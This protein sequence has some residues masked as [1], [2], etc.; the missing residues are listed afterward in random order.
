[1]RLAGQVYPLRGVVFE[2]ARLLEVV[3]HQQHSFWFEISHISFF[4][5]TGICAGVGAIGKHLG[6]IISNADGFEIE[7]LAGGNKLTP[8]SI[9]SA[10]KSP[11]RFLL[12]W[13]QRA[14][15]GRC[16]WRCCWRCF[17]GAERVVQKRR[18]SLHEVSPPCNSQNTETRLRGRDH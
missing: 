15:G 9:L 17:R 10:S 6:S 7:A 13:E 4:L 12:R 5:I 11:T 2:A 16:R 14:A 8:A 3:H 18:A 1:M